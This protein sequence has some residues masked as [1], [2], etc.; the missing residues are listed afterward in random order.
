[1]TQ[2]V[3]NRRFPLMD[4]AR[5]LAAL[6]VF[7][8]HVGYETGT[9]AYSRPLGL[10]TGYLDVG[11]AVFFAISGFLLYRQFLVARRSG[12]DRN[13]TKYARAR[14]LRIVPA[15]WVALTLAALYPTLIGPFTNRWWVF[16]GFFQ[17][18][19]VDAVNGLPQAWSLSVEVTFYCALPL[20]AFLMARISRGDRWLLVEIATLWSLA[21]A[22]AIYQLNASLYTIIGTFDWFTVGMTLAA[23]SVW[24]AE[25]HRLPRAL[26]SLASRPTLCWAVA[27]V[28]YVTVCL[29]N[30]VRLSPDAGYLIKTGGYAVT[31]AFLMI[32]VTLSPLVGAP[33]KLL[34]TPVIAWLGTI[35]YGIFLYH[36]PVL[37]AIQRLGWEYALRSQLV[38]YTVIGL[39]ATCVLAAL[40][41]YLVERPFLLLK[42][43]PTEAAAPVPDQ[44]A[45]MAVAESS[46][47]GQISP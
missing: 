45:A 13:L 5:A 4:G 31:A 16:Y 20:F 42:S 21:I 3:R 34:S 2:Q 6:A 36:L 10:F 43:K 35:S 32:P 37:I 19:T 18:Y 15:Y 33:S 8:Y 39:A 12:R 29:I 22:G 24:V 44:L 14:V 46:A 25:D 11:V 7:G 30:P 26:A 27:A 41:W 1:M 23:I 47:T 9:N 38:S 17:D 40:S 28:A